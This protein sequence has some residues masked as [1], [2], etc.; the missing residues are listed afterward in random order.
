MKVKELIKA[1]SK[2]PQDIEVRICSTDS[3]YYGQGGNNATMGLLEHI[4][5]VRVHKGYNFEE[6]IITNGR[7]YHK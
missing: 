1:L 4:E 6:V 2:M 5:N 3:A 7:Y